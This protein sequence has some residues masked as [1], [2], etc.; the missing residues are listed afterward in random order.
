M[1]DKALEALYEVKDE[2][3]RIIDSYSLTDWKNK[4]SNLI[5]RIYGK[6]SL[7]VQQIE[8]FSYQTGLRGGDNIEQ[9]KKQANELI[10][11]LIKEIERFGLPKQPQMKDNG[12]NI[13]ITQTQNQ[14]TKISLSIFIESIQDEL[15]GTQLKEL[16]AVIEDKDLNRDDK[17]H[18]IINK[19]KS[20]GSDVASNILANV[21]TNPS[22]F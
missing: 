6:D 10:N 2:T 12:L 20:F 15:T 16:Q 13:N 18:Q 11:G 8:N 3:N 5:I 17:K 19:I 22:I 1:K 21:L 4:A 9:R 7:P 14:E